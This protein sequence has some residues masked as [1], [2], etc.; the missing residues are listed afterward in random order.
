MK[1]L[2]L[3]TLLAL[4][5]AFARLTAAQMAGSRPQITGIS[6]I[7]VYVSDAAKSETFYV[8]DLGAFKGVDPENPQGVRYY[9]SPTQFV[10]VLPLPPGYAS[11]NRLDHV[12]FLTS[13]VESLR[14]YMSG[15]GVSVPT[16]VQ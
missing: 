2:R 14:K 7:G 13:G 12:A 15:H 10:E 1:R 8:H 3:V 11:I 4:M 6:H 5:L 9:F 16:S